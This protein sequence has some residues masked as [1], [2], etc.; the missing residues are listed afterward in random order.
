MNSKYSS[1]ICNLNTLIS[2]NISVSYNA[3]FLDQT[4]SV[5]SVTGGVVIKGGLGIAKNLNVGNEFYVFGNSNILSNINITKDLN[6]N[7][8]SN[9]SGNISVSKFNKKYLDQSITINHINGSNN[10]SQ[11]INFEY[12]GINIG[13]IMQLNTNSVRYNTTSDYRIKK[14]IKNMFPVIDKINKLN[15]IEFKY[16]NNNNNDNDDN[17]KYTNLGFIA[18]EI[19]EIFPYNYLVYGNKNE[20]E[21]HCIICNSEQ[22]MCK[23]INK[24]NTIIKPKYQTLDYGQL[25]PICIKGIQELSQE[26]KILQNNIQ[27]LYKIIKELEYSIKK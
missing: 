20:I 23:C 22:Y 7:E 21:Y 6:V 2:K 15:P 14:N 17:N 9:F 25:T 19:Q 8:Y 16:I 12:N 4:D 3:H 26:N 24:H 1:I 10:N 27:E 11:F 18:H 13:N 5:S